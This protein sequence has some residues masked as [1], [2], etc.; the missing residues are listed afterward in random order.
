MQLWGLERPDGP[1]A[2]S[3]AGTEKSEGSTMVVQD[4]ACNIPVTDQVEM[5]YTGAILEGSIYEVLRQQ[6]CR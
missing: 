5:H 6:V 3:H 4:G 1:D 2:R